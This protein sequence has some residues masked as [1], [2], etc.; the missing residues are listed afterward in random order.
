MPRNLVRAAVPLAVAVV[1]VAASTSF[2]RGAEAPAWSAPPPVDTAIWKTF[3]WRSIGPNRGGRSIA[4]SGVKG[5]PK[6]GYF[7]PAEGAPEAFRRLATGLDVAIVRVVPSGPGL[8]P[9]RAV[10]RACRPERVVS[11][12]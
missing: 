3:H 7:G 1:A 11:P 5:Q 6:V 9:I 10:M 2:G 8:E 12:A 4:V